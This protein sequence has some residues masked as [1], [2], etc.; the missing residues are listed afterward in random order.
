MF[1]L[2]F[3]LI[4]M[5]LVFPSDLVTD[6]VIQIRGYQKTAKISLV[7][8]ICIRSQDIVKMLEFVFYCMKCFEQFKS[9]IEFGDIHIIADSV[10]LPQVWAKMLR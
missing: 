4:I 7:V 10:F 9:L 1:Y 5:L 6:A 3:E 8:Y 2:G